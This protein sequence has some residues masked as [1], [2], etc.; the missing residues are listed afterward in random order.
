[1]EAKAKR[2][3][4]FSLEHSDR[5]LKDLNNLETQG[6]Q[7]SEI[8]RLRKIVIDLSPHLWPK[9]EPKKEPEP[10]QV[11]MTPNPT[12]TPNCIN[13]NPT[14]IADITDFYKIRK[15]TAPGSPSSEGPK[16]HSFIWTEYQRVPLYVPLDAVLDAGSY[17]KDKPDSPA[18]YLLTFDVKGHCN[19]KFRFDHVD[20]PIESVRQNMPAIPS[21]SDS[22]TNPV[23]NRIEFKAGELIGYTSGTMQA[24]NWDFGLYN[25]AQKGALAESYGMHAYSVCWPDFY[26]SEK[27]TQYRNLLEGPKLVCSF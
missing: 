21:V 23:A 19:F 2:G 11:V 10:G 9:P 14:L 4:Y 20:E 8:E 27:R 7:K 22:R 3:I 12:P 13:T 17:G 26:S 15:I 25:M 24:G 5:I 16:G 6:Y 18:Q 1:M